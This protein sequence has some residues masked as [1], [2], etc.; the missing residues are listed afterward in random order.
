[1]E[2]YEKWIAPF[3]HTHTHTPR[4]SYSKYREA[5]N[6]YLKPEIKKKY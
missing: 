3:M 1:M 4:I 5:G 2:P 6:L